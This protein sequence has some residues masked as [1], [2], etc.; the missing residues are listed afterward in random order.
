MARKN[1]GR[2]FRK[3]VTKTVLHCE[4]LED[5]RLLAA[6]VANQPY[7]PN[8]VLIQY[9]ANAN[10]AQK[11]QALGLVKGTVAETIHTKAMQSAGVGQLER[12]K[13]GSGVGIETAIAALSKNPMV[14]FA[15]PNYVYQPS[16]VS[17]DTYYTNGSLWGM[18]GSD[19]PSTVGPAGT[20][21]QYGIDAERAW[22]ANITGSASVVVGVIDEGIQVDHPDLVGNVWVNPYDP[23]DGVDNDGN[24]FV[25]DVNGW[26]FVNNDRTV[27]DGTG[28]D[29]ATHVAGTIGGKGSNGTGV[30]GVNWNVTMISTKFLGANGG[31]TSDAVRALDYLSDLKAR[32][33]INIVATNNSWGGGGYSQ[34][35]HDAIIRSA[36]RNI[37][38]VAAA[39]NGGSDGIGDSNDS[40]ASYPS[41]YNTTIGTSTQSAASYDS[42]IAV[43]SITSS[44]AIS[45]FSNYGATTVDIGAP[46]S[47]IY[48]TLPGG[49]YGSYSGTSMATPH[50]TGAVALYASTQPVGASAASIRSAILNSATPTASLAGKTVTGG[51]LNVFNAIQSAS[52]IRMDQAVYGIPGTVTVSVQNMSANVSSSAIETVTAQISS[53]T[54]GTPEVIT[55]TETGANTGLFVGTINLVSGSA[56]ADGVL[57]VANG[58]QISAYNAGV[59][60]TAV[61]TVDTVAPTI[62]SLTS[63]PRSN[64][65]DI[66]WTTNEAATTEVLFGTSSTSLSNTYNDATTTISHTAQLT[67]LS[68]ATTYYYQVRSRDAVGNVVTSATGSFTTTNPAPILFVDDDQGATFERFFT[69]A[70]Q[71]NN[72][73]FD[74]WNVASIGST[75]TASQLAAYGLVVWNTGYDYSSAGAGLS[76]TAEQT[77]IQGY[78]D[79]GGR[80]FISGQDILYSGVSATFRANYLKVAAFTSDVAQASHTETGVVGNAVSNGQSLTVAQPAD[81]PA[82]FVDALSP[83]A[84]AEGTYLHGVSTAA[85]PYS[86]INYRG[87]YATGGFGIVFSALPFETISSTAA[88][89]NNQATVMKRV[90]EYLTGTTVPGISVS[91]PTPSATT[92][93]IGGA[94][95]F[96]VV[97]D[98]APTADVTIPVSVSDDTEGTV[99]KTSLVFTPTNWAT[100]QTVTVS[101]VNDNV[102]DGNIAYSVVLA[103][104][105]SSDPGYNGKNPTD[106][107]LTNQDD[108]TAGVTVSA[109]TP[110]NQ[111]SENLGA[112]SF[113]IKLNSEPTSS[114]KID[115]SSSD[116]T[117]GI[118]DVPSVT[119]DATNW[120]QPQTITVT[121]VDDS[122]YDGNITYTILT[123]AASSTDPLY[124]NRAVADVSLINM[125]NDPVPS[126][127]FYVVDDATLN[128]TYEYSDGGVA[129]RNT[130]VN[131][132]N[133]T[134]RG[135]AMTA[136]G[137]RLWVVDGNRTVHIYDTTTANRQWLGSWTA[138]TLASNA[139]VQGIATDGTHIWI[140]DS[141][142]DRVFYYANAATRLSGTQTATSFLLGS[143]NTTPTDL[144]FGS[145]S[146]NNRFLWVVDSNSIDR[147]YRYSVGATGGITAAGNWQLNSANSTP[148][149]ITLDPSNGSQDIWVVDSGTDRVYR[150]ANA[151]TLTSPTL[152]DS[153]ALAAGN[154]NPQGIADPPAMSLMSGASSTSV[155]STVV[156]SAAPMITSN[157]AA[158]DLLSRTASAQSQ[159]IVRSGTTGA[160]TRQLTVGGTGD[161]AIQTPSTTRVV[162]AK[163]KPVTASSNAA[164][165]TAGAHDA[166]FA[167][168][169]DVLGA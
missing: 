123:S 114:V 87:N 23:V 17:N 105:V 58:N 8:E 36:N 126:S 115:I 51:R 163:G 5:R 143:G 1:L 158:V 88:T 133:A 80:I 77:A 112:V 111:T 47:S 86:A 153:F 38:F 121:G 53:T 2:L 7:A 132:N 109:P 6:V 64:S 70:L 9:V 75:P 164:K 118:V 34:S 18:Y 63:T 128:L 74:T 62:S 13:L 139:N 95:S 24:G 136:S 4:Q 65:A 167:N 54:E 145:D 15:E 142:S 98:S 141:R 50:V 124:G 76:G 72:Y 52:S 84:G 59:N 42:V 22:N 83:V 41:N 161:R 35:L 169:G 25:D 97:L 43:A 66:K 56:V 159:A 127:K 160:E 156:G 125:D 122:V 82:L 100:P 60:K 73:V 162:A 78:L 117:E 94:V 68:A 103:A 168:L 96:S 120:S 69:A 104:A 146:S 71:A 85:Y 3:L 20:T 93:E 49:T 26:D 57:Q 44:G 107:S 154:T 116:T 99:N 21:N 30:A 91:A 147:V 14:K 110:N 12:V 29:H 101:G 108:D 151:R 113:T 90:V 138:G 48:S 89:P 102:D 40:L 134:P 11:A 45:S 81:F 135:A 19:S 155:A 149:G 46:G 106:V 31:Y 165:S 119:F 33:G 148:T 166:F 55:L 16:A 131:T 140:V 32:H 28:D 67:G 10:A 27:Y 150:Y 130:S 39:G 152:T 37:L 129:V 61:A 137:N 157:S 79:G 144:V 92:T